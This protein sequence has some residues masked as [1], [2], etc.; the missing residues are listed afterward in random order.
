MAA[1]LNGASGEAAARHATGFGCGRSKG[2]AIGFFALSFGVPGAL[3]G[4]AVSLVAHR[5][6]F[7]DFRPLGGGGGVRVLVSSLVAGVLVVGGAYV[8]F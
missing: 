6:L 4:F 8:L 1:P 2:E 7:R 5:V 3:A